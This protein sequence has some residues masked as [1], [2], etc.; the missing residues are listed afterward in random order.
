MLES[1]KTTRDMFGTDGVRGIANRGFMTPEA[2]MRLGYAYIEFLKSKGIASPKIAVGMD[3]RISG[4]ML[5][6]ALTAGVVSAGGCMADLEVIPTPGV[7]FA[8][9]RGDFD[10]GAVVSASHNPA[11]Y[12]GVKFLDKDGFKLTDGDELAIEAFYES[13]CLQTERPCGI[14][15]G[16]AVD[17]CR[18]KEDYSEFLALLLN[19][20]KDKSYAVAID[21]ANGA[22]SGFIQPLMARWHGR[23]F[24]YG[25]DPD[26]KNINDGVGVTHMDFICAKTVENK[27]KLGIAYDGDTDRV[28]F[29]DEFGRIIDGDI[30]LWVTSRWLARLGRLGSG[31][32]ATVMTNM[33]LEDLLREEGINVFRCDV[34]DRYVLETMRREGCR[35]GGEQSGHILAL[36]YA[37]TGDGLC[38][39]ILFLRALTELGEAPSS[40][41]DRFKRYPQVLRN[42]KVSDNKSVMRD[43]ALCGSLAEAEKMLGGN[44]RYSLRPSGTEPL[45]RVFVESRDEALMNRVADFLENEIRRVLSKYE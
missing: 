45:I 28:L 26:G 22:A 44:G 37:N 17:G 8:V 36:D 19:E 39:G 7:S 20:V 18:A 41:V 4:E 13:A 6:S 30:M 24:L 14:S 33:V 42:I 15:V 2:V 29:S 35:L 3:T 32:V 11:E 5:K 10:G 21:A 43:N 34:G 38:S 23:V 12:N 16:K 31:V 40:L 1:G 27:A 25:C 9:Q